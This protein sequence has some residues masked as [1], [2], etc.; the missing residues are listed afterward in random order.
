M[1]RRCAA[2]EEDLAALRAKSMADEAEM[3]N[4]K[5]AI[6]ELTRER[7]EAL[8]SLLFNLMTTMILWWTSLKTR[9]AT[10]TCRQSRGVLF[11]FFFFFF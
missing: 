5:R 11:R 2:V 9:P 6:M 10:K 7:K 8:I 4:A 3:K 1:G